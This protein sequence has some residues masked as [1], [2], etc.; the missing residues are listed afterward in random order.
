MLDG[1]SRIVANAL[2]GSAGNIRI[3]TDFLFRSSDSEIKASNRF[4]VEGNVDIDSPDT[5]V[6]S[7]ALE[8]PTSFLDAASLLSDRCSARTAKN[9][10]SFIVSDRG[11]VPPGPETVLPSYSL[12]LSEAPKIN[13]GAAAISED[14]RCNQ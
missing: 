12:N 1:G 13:Q 2:E 10:S 14:Q 7:S 4:G 3:R 9:A 11:G 8:L 6:I 5:D